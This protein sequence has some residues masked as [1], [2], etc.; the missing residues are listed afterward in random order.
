[1]AGSVAY[2]LADKMPYHLFPLIE[3]AL[4]HPLIRFTAAFPLQP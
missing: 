3:P 2:A 4:P 1:M